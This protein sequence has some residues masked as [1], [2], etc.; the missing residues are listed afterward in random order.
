MRSPAAS[1]GGITP[2]QFLLRLKSG[3]PPPVCLFAGAEAYRREKCR[4]ALIDAALAPEERAE[5]LIRHDLDEVGL[6]EVI[7]DARALSLFAPRRVIWASSAE[8]ALPRGRV[9]AESEEAA[10]D[11]KDGGIGALAAYVQDPTPGT[12][13]VFESSR[14]EF[15]GEDKARLER[16]QKF[17][18]AVPMQ[19]EFRSYTEEASRAVAREIAREKGLNIGVAELGLLIEALGGDAARIAAEMEKL[20]LYAQQRKVTAEDI[21]SLVPNARAST[22]FALVGSLGRGDRARSLDILDSL[23]RDGEYLPLALTFLATQFR[24]ALTAREAGLRTPQQILA[25]FSKIGVRIWPDRANQVQQTVAAFPPGKLEEA[26]QR[27]FR[28]DRSLREPRP[29]DR[30]VLEELIF[31]L[32]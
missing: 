28:A 7:D 25:H 17:Y 24:L 29:D 18:A 12:V 4:R 2:E 22:V 8:A 13:L 10:G 1:A 9:I 27:I 19:V 5:G 11:E 15:D 6:T 32:T 21:V 31:S 3:G 20:S 26:L 30:V 14:W 23:V 16:V